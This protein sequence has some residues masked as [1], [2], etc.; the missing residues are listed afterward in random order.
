MS[1]DNGE[2]EALEPVP[3]HI[4]AHATIIQLFEQKKAAEARLDLA[5]SILQQQLGLPKTWEYDTAKQAFV[6]PQAPAK[7]AKPVAS[8]TRGKR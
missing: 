8:R 4:A 5:V 6:P 7:P 3:V 1:K 2:P